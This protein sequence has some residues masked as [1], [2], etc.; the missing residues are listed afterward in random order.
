MKMRAIKS[1]AQ[2]SMKTSG[3]PCKAWA[4]KLP[5]SLDGSQIIANP[6]H[7]NQNVNFAEAFNILVT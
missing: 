7:Q 3:K 2:L 5:I 1:F 6:S 4:H